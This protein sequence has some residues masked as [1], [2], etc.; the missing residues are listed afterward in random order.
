MESTATPAPAADRTGVEG[1]GPCAEVVDGFSE[2][3]RRTTDELRTMGSRP[4]RLADIDRRLIRFGEIED[5]TLISEE[6]YQR[7]RPA[8]RRLFDEFITELHRQQATVRSA[9][10]EPGVIADAFG[11]LE[12]LWRLRNPD[13]EPSRELS[14]AV[15]AR[16]PEDELL[17]IAV[18]ASAART[19]TTR[20]SRPIL[21][22]AECWLLDLVASSGSGRQ[23]TSLIANVAADEREATVSLWE[24]DPAAEFHRLDAVLDAVRRLG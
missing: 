1:Q 10:T 21:V 6:Q 7:M 17:A 15:L 22:A 11:D 14:L 16:T 2:T 23:I 3:L 19:G 8:Q 4:L 13:V 18:K 9:H 5:E 12:H 20:T 24:D